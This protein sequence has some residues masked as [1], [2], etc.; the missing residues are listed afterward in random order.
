MIATALSAHHTNPLLV[1]ILVK[2]FFSLLQLP[3]RNFF[4]FLIL[5]VQME[6]FKN[7]CFERSKRHHQD[8]FFSFLFSL[9]QV[10][11]RNLNLKFSVLRELNNTTY[12]IIFFPYNK[13]MWVYLDKFLHMGITE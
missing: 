6:G 1:L 8:F 11:E 7:K 10:G 3:D 5:Q 2:S 9:L 4:I 12:S 13:W